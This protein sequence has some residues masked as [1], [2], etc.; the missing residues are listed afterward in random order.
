[1]S[2]FNAK[3]MVFISFEIEHGKGSSQNVRKYFLKTKRFF[4]FNFRREM[5]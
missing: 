5:G 4:Y 2:N 3:L 1:M